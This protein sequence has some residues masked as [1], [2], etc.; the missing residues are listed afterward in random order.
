[1]RREMIYAEQADVYGK[2]DFWYQTTDTTIH[3]CTTKYRKVAYDFFRQ[4]R[5]ISELYGK[6]TWKRKKYLCKLIE[7]K[8]KRELRRVAC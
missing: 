6:R 7:T 5:S 8:L 1:M 4:G 3:L 2:L